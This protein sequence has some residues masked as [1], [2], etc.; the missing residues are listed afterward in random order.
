MPT[1]KELLQIKIN[2]D[3]ASGTNITAAKHRDVESS[4]MNA[5]I[6][7][8]RGYF[9]G[10]DVNGTPVGTY[11]SVGGDI[12]Q[13]VVLRQV[14]VSVVSVY[15]TSMINTNYIVKIHVQST[16]ADQ[17]LDAG[18]GCPTF[19]AVS[20]TN[21]YIGIKELGEQGTQNLRFHLEV[22]SLDY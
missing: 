9:T 20:A 16:G 6:P 2:T 18:G 17:N 3:L 4:I 22:V 13:A 11:L 19:R 15:F 5:A 12:T 8:N 14:D 1:R 21:A 10:L 7:A